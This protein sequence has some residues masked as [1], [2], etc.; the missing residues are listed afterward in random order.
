MGHELARALRRHRR[1]FCSLLGEAGKSAPEPV[2]PS[3][4]VMHAVASYDATIDLAGVFDRAPNGVAGAQEKFLA[5]FGWLLTPSD[6]AIKG[7]LTGGMPS[8]SPLPGLNSRSR[9]ECVSHFLENFF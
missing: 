1:F 6:S 9:Q 3:R 2:C 5:I 8:K 4:D 7:G